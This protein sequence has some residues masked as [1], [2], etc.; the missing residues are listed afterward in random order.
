[1]VGIVEAFMRVISWTVVIGA[2]AAIL[3]G[4]VRPLFQDLRLPEINASQA[5]GTMARPAAS[6]ENSCTAAQAA[7]KAGEQ[8]ETCDE[9]APAQP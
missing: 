3:Y 2:I 1:M 8:P 6:S 9:P 4:G 7:A 5:A